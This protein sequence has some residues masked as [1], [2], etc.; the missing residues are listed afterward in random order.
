[1][2]NLK[3]KYYFWKQ[4]KRYKKFRNCNLPCP[5]F[6]KKRD[7]FEWVYYDGYRQNG[8]DIQTSLYEALGNVSKSGVTYHYEAVMYGQKN[9]EE[10]EA[11]YQMMLDHCHSF[12]EVIERVYRYPETFHIPDNYLEEYSKQ[13]LRCLKKIQS[14]LKVIGLPDDK[15]SSDIIALNEKWQEINDKKR[16][17]IKD[18]YFLLGYSKRWKKLIEKENMKR[19]VNEKVLLYSSYCPLYCEKKEIAEAYLNGQKDYILQR[20]YSF[21]NETQVGKKYILVNSNSEYCGTLEVISEEFIPF[22]ELKAEKVNYKMAGYKTFLD[23]KK[24]LYDDYREDGKMF[25]E[26]FTEDSLLIYLRVKVL[27]RF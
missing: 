10:K 5:F 16:K 3:N 9:S 13:E 11:K 15:E 18:Y 22:K 1:M 4:N 21:N 24:H 23:Y 20:K 19:Y 14:Y 2:R 26:E 12:D 8:Y 7:T 17:S 25:D 6:D 27:E